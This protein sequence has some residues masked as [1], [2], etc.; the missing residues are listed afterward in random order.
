M[1][2]RSSIV[3]SRLCVGLEIHVELS[4]LAKMFT[5]IA[6]VAHPDHFDAPANSLIDPVV[7]GLPGALPVMNKRAIEQSMLVGLALNCTI[8]EHTTW[9]R[10]N[11]FYPDLPKGYQISQY[12]DPVCGPGHLEIP[13]HDG[14]TARIGI[15]RAHL[16]EDAG[17]LGHELPGGAHYDGSLVD[18]NRAGT[19][20]LEIVT[21]PD[22]T[23]AD[24]V[25]T[26]AQELR[27]ICRFLRVTEGDMQRGHMRFEPN[28]NLH[29][30]LDDGTTI[31]T[32][33]VEVKN[34]N[35]FRAVHGA[36]THEATRQIEQWCAD[37]VVMG[38][39]T[40][41]TRGWDDQRDVTFLQRSKEDA[42]D[43]RYFP[44][45]D[46]PPVVIDDAWRNAVATLLPELPLARRARY[47]TSFG[48]TD[49]E[50][51]ALVDDRE[52][53]DFYEAC[54]HTA[55]GDVDATG[56]AI[57]KMLLN[58]GA[59][60]ANETGVGIHELGITPAQV[61]GAVTLRRH[62]E[63]GST[64]ADTL[65]GLLCTTDASAHE[66]A[67]REQ[68]LQVTDDTQVTA[69]IDA[70]INAEPDSATDVAAG[71]DA[72]I[73]RLIGAVMKASGGQA[74]AKDIRA[75]LLQ[76]LRS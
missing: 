44:E 23:H 10:K 50:A 39:N 32:P 4:T 52:H 5:R 60:R 6:N 20:L 15:I 61:F 22:F 71:K 14:T 33:I 70:A 45:P 40:K 3:A 42:M 55:G 53:C 65:F 12:G 1:P 43:Y 37:G 27:A 59:K 64:A 72:A 7:L 30:T 36:I 38:P 68:L 16:E 35:S 67:E 57:A 34:L 28:I 26:F 9:D 56:G 73:G 63:I 11:Y 17:K 49:K 19:P 66:V 46:L 58:A 8:A 51:R 29:V 24:D 31:A 47:V 13:S 74:D 69:W 25:V 76:R 2:D 21:A 41:T 62:N 48:I 54:L 75:R 18:Y